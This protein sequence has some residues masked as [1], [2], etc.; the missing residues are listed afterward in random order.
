MSTR[1][2]ILIKGF[3]PNLYRH[4][5]GYPDSECGV[6]ATL[7]PFLTEFMKGHGDD[8]SYMLARLA[9]AQ[10]NTVDKDLEDPIH[11]RG[12]RELMRFLGYG[13]DIGLHADLAYIYQID[14]KKR[15]VNVLK[16]KDNFWD[17]PK[18]SNAKRVQVVPF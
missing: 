4:S 14:T 9:Q 10:T 16:T 13:I 12:G 11:D 5:D 2:Q 17:A 18:L 15:V 7:I 1:C 8:P 3:T 6:L